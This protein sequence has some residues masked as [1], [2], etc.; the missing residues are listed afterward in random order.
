MSDV[1]HILDRAQRGDPKAAEELVPLVY[2]ELR[3]LAAAKMAQQAPGQ[4]LQATT[5]VH[6]AYLRLIG[7]VRDQWH[8]DPL[9]RKLALR[10]VA[11]A[12]GEPVGRLDRQ[13]A[14]TG[15]ILTRNIRQP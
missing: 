5:L 13:S 11:W 9:F 10:G 2:E 14:Y 12:A 15:R 3:K 8:D 6:A 1:T 7:G 4:A